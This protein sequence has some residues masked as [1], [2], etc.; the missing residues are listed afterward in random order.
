MRPVLKVSN[1]GKNYFS[2]KPSVK[3]APLP[4][5]GFVL[6]GLNFE[7]YAGDVLGLVGSNGS[8]KSTLLKMLASTLK[9]TE[10]QIESEGRTTAILDV[11]QGFHPDLSGMENIFL[12]GQLQGLSKPE[13]KKHVDD[14]VAFSELGEYIGQPVKN[15]SSGMFLRLAFSVS[16]FLSADILLLD[17][18]IAVGDNDFREKCRNK[19]KDLVAQGKTLVIASHDTG[20]LASLCNKC[21]WLEQGRQVAFNESQAVIHQYNELH[22]GKIFKNLVSAQQV[23]FGNDA[24]S[25]YVKL[26]KMLVR[27][28]NSAVGDK[29]HMW[30][31]LDISIHFEK[32]TTQPLVMSVAITDHAGNPLMGISSLR[33][34]EGPMLFRAKGGYETS[35]TLP[36]NLFNADY[37]RIS[38]FF[39]DER[40]ELVFAKEDVLVFKV[41]SEGENAAPHSKNNFSGPFYPILKWET[42]SIL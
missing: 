39:I 27:K 34:A 5:N 24:G 21:L 18:V 35:V 26:H 36:K 28:R 4:G 2:N 41:F 19:I 17:E 32:Q 3:S 8:G 37:F 16:V 23:E 15:Y 25:E 22:Y 42:K 10:G 20:L 11:G 14:I 13:I 1:L 40:E 31:E 9:P 38:V 7:I 29:I 12:K 30:D 33:G 6:T